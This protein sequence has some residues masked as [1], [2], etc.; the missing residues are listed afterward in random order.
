M[1]RLGALDLLSF[2]EVPGPE[3][4][5]TKEAMK[6]ALAAAIPAV[7]L[8]NYFTNRVE[9]VSMEIDYGSKEFMNFLLA[10]EN[11]ISKGQEPFQAKAKASG[12]AAGQPTTAASGRP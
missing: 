3:D 11:R 1:R 8:Y 12:G 10:I 6:A 2:D 7:W 4:P 5:P 9:L